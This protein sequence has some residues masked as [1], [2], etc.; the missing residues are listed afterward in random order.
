[1]FQETKEL[2][3][4]GSPVVRPYHDLTAGIR[5]GCLMCPKQLFG[6]LSDGIGACVRGAMV[7]GGIKALPTDRWS[8]CPP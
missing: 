5:R 4:T 7:A 6:V 8:P 2:S 1:M 3:T